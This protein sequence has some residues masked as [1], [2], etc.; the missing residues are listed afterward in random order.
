MSRSLDTNRC[1]GAWEA[2]GQCPHVVFFPK[3]FKCTTSRSKLGSV[4]KIIGWRPSL[5]VSIS[6]YNDARLT[7]NCHD[8]PRW[9]LETL[10]AKRQE[11][12]KGLQVNPAL[13]ESCWRLSRSAVWRSNCRSS[14]G[15]LKNGTSLTQTKSSSTMFDHF[16]HR[17]KENFLLRSPS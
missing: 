10:E 17:S 8:S 1:R 3:D 15:P 6:V 14:Q 16:G 13:R 9:E 5:L 4:Y 7:G 11:L 12:S 2:M